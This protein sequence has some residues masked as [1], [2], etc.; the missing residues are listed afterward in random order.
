MLLGYATPAGIVGI[1]GG[2]LF[3]RLLMKKSVRNLS[4]LALIITGI[5]VI[6]W[7][8]CSSIP[9]YLILLMVIMFCSSG[10]SFVAPTLMA[11]W[12]PRK[13]GV[14][15]G[16]ATIGA[17]LSSSFGVLGF[18]ALLQ[19]FGFHTAFL[20]LGIIVIVIGVVSFF[21]VKDDP[22]KVGQLPDNMD[23]AV[24][25]KLLAE[26]GQE[27]IVDDPNLTAGKV[28]KTGNTWLIEI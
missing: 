22:S 2:F 3:A 14:A 23:P 17:P 27:V 26:A 21:W 5:A 6:V 10:L 7:S 9:M 18:S 28:L 4:A 12:F 20:V 24:G 16:W 1:I 25:E 19:N 15:L 8:Y 13:K 11:D